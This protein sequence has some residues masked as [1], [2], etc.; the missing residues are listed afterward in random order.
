MARLTKKAAAQ[1]TAYLGELPTERLVDLVMSQAE[2]DVELRTRLLLEAASAGG[3]PLDVSSY[4]RSF[5]DALRSGSANRRDHARTSGPW[6]RTVLGVV[7]QIGD[8]LPDHA[9]A[10][11]DV[12][13]YALGRV[14]VTMSRVDDS[15]GW[16]SQITS[17]LENIHHQACEIVRPE[18]I[19]LARR[20]FALDVDSEWDIL[21]DAPN[22]YAEVLGDDGLSELQRLADERWDSLSDSERASA[23]RGHFHLVKM[24]EHLA[25]AA[26]DVDARVELLAQDLSYPYHYVK[27]A[28][29]LLEADRADDAL[30]WAERG[31]A[32]FDGT[33]HQM[34][35]DSRLDDVALAGWA[36][37]GRT[38]EVD[39][40]V[41]RRFTEKP[42]SATYQRLKRWTTESGS[43]DEYEL[44]A[45]RLLEERAT[46]SAIAVANRPTPINRY[47][48]ARI[49]APATH[50]DLIAVL[51]WED[52]LDD[53]WA[54]ANEHGAS[55]SVWLQLAAASDTDRPLDAARAYAR[56]VEAQLDRKRYEAAVE[57]LGHI[58]MLYERGGDP[59]TFEAY[60]ADL[61]QRHRQKTKLMRLLGEAGLADPGS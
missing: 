18:P 60:L 14:D 33:D 55:L 23:G 54:V 15:S 6:A 19:A 50:D 59:R 24:R 61:C 41:W 42:G 30:A 17:D 10:V 56:D 45:V 26:G 40:L 53:A 3:G 51:T 49:P 13:E 11:I 9:A 36:E 22:R 21:Y 32:A 20:L 58:R 35:G 5:S 52:R 28:E 44:R 25:K 12:T 4:R 34:R 1:L 46:A 47:V 48:A 43:C 37:R 2:H 7:G 31:L 27:I 57:R 39:D 8:L 29:V 16:F 38:A